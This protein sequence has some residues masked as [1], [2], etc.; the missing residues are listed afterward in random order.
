MSPSS[1]R[2]PRIGVVVVAG[3]SGQRLGYGMP[4]AQV[5]LAGEPMLLHTLR[6]VQAADIAS[7]IV[8]AVPAGDTL[9]R[10]ICAEF[11]AAVRAVDGG[12]TRPESVRAA[13]AVLPADLDAVLVHDAARALTP[14][15]VFHRVAAALAAGA[16]A[17]IPAVPVVDT[18]KDTAPVPQAE[19]AAAERRVTGTPDRARLRA[20]QTPQGFDA[21]LLRRA[22]QAALSFD[23]A[24][25]AAV[26]DDAMLVE[27]LGAEVYVVEGSQLSLKITTPLDLVLAEAI[28]AGGHHRQE[29]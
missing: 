22:H 24:A 26:T 21:A 6:A 12:A 9:M 10:G 15:E 4:K 29:N 23:P 18:V 2:P 17:V 19:S 27:S 7:A 14:P 28:L 11:G 20:V 8:V 1:S 5:P 25:A 16:T 13:L 3:G